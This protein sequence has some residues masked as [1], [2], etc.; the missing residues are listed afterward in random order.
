[1]K[2]IAKAALK[3]GLGSV[4]ALPG[5]G[6][7]HAS[8]LILVN[9]TIYTATDHKWAKAI[10][11]TDGK[12]EAVGSDAEVLKTK[13]ARTKVVDLQGKMVIPGVTDDHTHIWF[14]S[15]ALNGFNLSTATENITPESNRALFVARIRAYAQAH[16]DMPILFGR[17]DF[18]RSGSAASLA[19]N[20][21]ILDEAVPDRPLVV[22]S[23]TEHSLYVNSRALALA[24]IT[25]KPLPDPVEEQY[26]VRDAAGHPTGVLREGA[27][28]VME[29]ALP[30]M[31]MDEKVRILGN[32]LHFMNSFGITSAAQLTG[33]LDDLKAFDELRKR[34]LLTLRVRQ[35]FGAV[36]VD[37]H[38]T[39]KFLADLETAR[40]TW[41]DDWISANIVKFFM[42]GAPTPPLYTAEEYTRIVTELDKRGY[43]LTSHALTTD[44]IK[45]A[46]DGYESAEKANG[47]KDRR[48]RME[49]GEDIRAADLPRFAGLGIV[50]STQPAFCCG[51]TMSPDAITSNPWNSLLKSGV[52]LVFSSDWPCSWPPNPLAGIEQAVMRYTWENPGKPDGSRAGMPSDGHAEEAVTAEQAL[53][54]YTRTAAWANH[55]DDK[56]GTLETGK[57]ADL[58][59]LSQNILAIPANQIGKTTV[60]ATVVGGRVVYGQLP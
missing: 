49:H 50:V 54:A 16:P 39:P 44:G 52:K 2:C 13:T 19:T 18:D 51:T 23:W 35:G 29:R 28:E 43:Y 37:H 22:H 11:I 12:I 53:L 21:A 55:M 9:G 25:D 1:M 33:G 17:A 15:L 7:A 56:L 32:G 38:L 59:V 34:G 10:A 24:G 57:L 40:T 30:P 20:K 3:A 46:L 14:G 26:I 31:P 47:P 27:Q 45:M 5:A 36:A 6:I 4:L 58:V 42:D 48:F 41:H 8:D 60:D